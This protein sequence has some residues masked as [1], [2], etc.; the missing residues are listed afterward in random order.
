MWAELFPFWDPSNLRTKF[1][2]PPQHSAYSDWGSHYLLSSSPCRKREVCTRFRSGS[3]T[4]PIWYWS[5]P[6]I[7]TWSDVGESVDD[8]CARINAVFSRTYWFSS[9][10]IISFVG[11]CR[12]SGCTPHELHAMSVRKFL[13]FWCYK[14]NA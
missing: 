11:N 9:F 6:R 4:F 7:Y 8:T 13:E 12:V 10:F 2:D 14:R 1:D 3:Y 5:E